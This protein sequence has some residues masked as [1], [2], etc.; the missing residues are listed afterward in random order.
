MADSNVL[1]RLL[2][3]FYNPPVDDNAN[4]SFVPRATPQTMFPNVTFT[5]SGGADKYATFGGG[6]VGVESNAGNGMF[7]VGL[8]G[9]G[10]RVPVAGI[11]KANLTGA[12]F[13][14][15]PNSLPGWSINGQY[16][17]QQMPPVI[18]EPFS[19]AQPVVMTTAPRTLQ[20]LMLG[21]T[22][23]F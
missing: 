6:R 20:S 7:S 1:S 15:A 18:Q 3:G 22:K 17:R 21:L 19:D 9:Q 12:D 11:N 8:S 10:L 13:S 4:V 23:R 14:Y 2:A 5:G 16:A